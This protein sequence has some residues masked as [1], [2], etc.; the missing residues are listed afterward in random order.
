MNSMSEYRDSAAIPRVGFW[1]SLTMREVYENSYTLGGYFPRG[2]T[3][4]S[5]PVG[6]LE[7]DSAD[8]NSPM[9]LERFLLRS[10]RKP[11]D[12]E[13]PLTFKVSSQ[14]DREYAACTPRSD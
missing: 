12:H 6:S 14:S 2:I 5:F 4:G 13:L 7:L 10:L 9:H 1:R 3:K 8:L 11:L